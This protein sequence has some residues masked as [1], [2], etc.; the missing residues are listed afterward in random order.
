MPIASLHWLKW[1]S[2]PN[3]RL[4][5]SGIQGSDAITNALALPHACSVELGVWGDKQVGLAQGKLS[6]PL[7][8]QVSKLLGFRVDVVY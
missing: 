3:L 2:V 8:S 1:P 5:V 7:A 6:T 4:V